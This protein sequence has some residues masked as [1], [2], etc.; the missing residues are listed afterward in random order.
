MKFLLFL[1]LCLTVMTAGAEA[2]GEENV[3]ERAEEMVW[4][5][6]IQLIANP[7]KYHGKNV[8]VSGFLHL[9]F[10]GHALYLHRDDALH[11]LSR[12][13]IWVDWY[14][15]EEGDGEEKLRAR[16]E[17][18]DRFLLPH[19]DQYVVMEGIFNAKNTGHFGLWS[20]G[21]E[22]IKRVFRARIREG[23]EKENHPVR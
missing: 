20:G 12:N 10:E 15:W 23:E 6:L 11:H 2:R 9:E 4:V 17:F 14:D 5:S 3:E 1:A 19:N 13:G 8:L 22:Q 16:N 21:I 7:E 18:F